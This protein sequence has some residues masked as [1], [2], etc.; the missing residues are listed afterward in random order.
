SCVTVSHQ[1]IST[2]KL[3][4]ERGGDAAATGV[5]AASHAQDLGVLPWL[6]L[7]A[8]LLFSWAVPLR[9]SLPLLLPRP[10]HRPRLVQARLT[11]AF[12]ETDRL[13]RPST[14]TR[15]RRP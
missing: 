11:E 15:S 12:H 5:S 10:G 14:R 1:K 3:S 2:K 4:L 9:P 8:L 7:P 13:L 6:F